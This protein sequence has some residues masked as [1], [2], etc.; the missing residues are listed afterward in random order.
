MKPGRAVGAWAGG[1]VEPALQLVG[2]HGAVPL[3]QIQRHNGRAELRKIAVY[4]HAG[5]LFYVFIKPAGQSAVV[6]ADAVHPRLVQ[7]VQR[8]AQSRDAVAV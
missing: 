8:G 6:G 2:N 1:D 4:R 3:P 7:P 5:E